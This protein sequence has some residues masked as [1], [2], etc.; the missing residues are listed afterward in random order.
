MN[1]R[2]QFRASHAIGVLVRHM[3][4]N[5]VPDAARDAIWSLIEIVETAAEAEAVPP[6]MDADG[7]GKPDGGTA[8]QEF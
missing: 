6:S 4:E 3:N 8:Y 2:D 1:T 7:P 5:A